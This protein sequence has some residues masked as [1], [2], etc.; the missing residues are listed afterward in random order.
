LVAA[1]AGQLVLGNDAGNGVVAAGQM[2]LSRQ[3]LGSEAGL[4]AQLDDLTF[5]ARGG[6]MRAVLGA[7]TLFL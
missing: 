2:E 6:L 3:T 5:Q 7:P 4:L 1:R